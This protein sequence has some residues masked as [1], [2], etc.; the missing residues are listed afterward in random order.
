MNNKTGF[1]RLGRTSSHRRALLKNLTMSLI[2][3]EKIITTQAKA[4][5]LR[6]FVEKLVTRARKDTVYNRRE[7]AKIITDKILLKKIFSVIGPRYVNRPGGYTRI[8]KLGYRRGDAAEK[9]V[10]ELIDKFVDSTIV[11]S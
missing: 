1:N 8:I 11:A 9:V 6:S 2:K 5:E 7:L 3:H 10:I 4:K